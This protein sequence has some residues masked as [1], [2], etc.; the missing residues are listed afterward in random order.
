MQGNIS[1]SGSKSIYARLKPEVLNFARSVITDKLALKISI[2]NILNN[3]LAH[4]G[5]GRN[6]DGWP[7]AITFRESTK[8]SLASKIWL[9]KHIFMAFRLH[10]QTVSLSSFLIKLIGTFHILCNETGPVYMLYTYLS[11]I[12]VLESQI[13]VLSNK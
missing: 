12:M 9:A 4:Q 1:T 8:I 6:H 11:Y 5:G 10:K 2:L 7:F 13:I 3:Q